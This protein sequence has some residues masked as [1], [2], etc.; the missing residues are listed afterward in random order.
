[1]PDESPHR[2][3]PPA[4]DGTLHQLRAGVLS[5]VRDPSARDPSLRQLAVVL[6]T[7]ARE[8]PHTIRGLATQLRIPKSTAFRAVERL[9]QIGWA[10]READP[11]DRRSMN[12]TTTPSG[13][14]AVAEIIAA[15]AVDPAHTSE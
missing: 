3:P 13:R 10:W 15:M 2:T 12:V 8:E 7:L 11:L 4:G 1:M 5:L 14:A 6:V 9:E